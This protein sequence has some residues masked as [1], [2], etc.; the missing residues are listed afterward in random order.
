MGWEVVKVVGR[1]RKS[2]RYVAASV[3][4]NHLMNWRVTMVYSPAALH[5]VQRWTYSGGGFWL[6]GHEDLTSDEYRDALQGVAASFENTSATLPR[7][8]IITSPRTPLHQAQPRPMIGFL[9]RRAFR[10]PGARE[11]F[12]ALDGR[13]VEPGGGCWPLLRTWPSSVTRPCG[14]V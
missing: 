1:P 6:R 10:A 3:P 11:R 8:S 14:P 9:R 13:R 4:A 12:S 5:C 7:R 2:G